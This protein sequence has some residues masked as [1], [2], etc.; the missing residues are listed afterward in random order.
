MIPSQYGNIP[1]KI[2]ELKRDIQYYLQDLEYLE[3]PDNEKE[4]LL[5]DR[6][7]LIQFYEGKINDNINA[8][9]DSQDD[10]ITLRLGNDKIR[11]RRMDILREY[12]TVN[13]I[14]KRDLDVFYASNPY[15]QKLY[16]D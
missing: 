8:C 1:S 3:N 11:R 15:C 7:S 10:R 5:N 12:D 6:H 13:N 9:G 4:I 16:T 2:R 14:T